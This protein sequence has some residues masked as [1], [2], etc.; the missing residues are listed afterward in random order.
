MHVIQVTFLVE[1]F[2]LL[3]NGPWYVSSIIVVF[4]IIH[5]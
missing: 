3:L 5:A 4:D 2:V 1:M